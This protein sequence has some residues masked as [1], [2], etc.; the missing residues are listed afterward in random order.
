MSSRHAS[1]SSAAS[2]D[3]GAASV[4]SSALPGRAVR[5]VGAGAGAGAG[6]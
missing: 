3:K 2:L 4:N 5:D 6:A 1:T